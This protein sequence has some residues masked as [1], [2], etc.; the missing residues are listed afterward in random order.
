MAVC[1][2]E[3][4]FHEHKTAAHQHPGRAF[5]LLHASSCNSVNLHYKLLK[6]SPGLAGKLC[7]QERQECP[8]LPDELVS[9]QC[10]EEQLNAHVDPT[11]STN[12]DLLLHCH[13]LLIGQH[14][15]HKVLAVCRTCRNYSL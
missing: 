5:G 8:L 6:S 15:L 2:L 14:L 11:F 1:L 12:E 7:N 13:V 4:S 9:N 3:V 10:P